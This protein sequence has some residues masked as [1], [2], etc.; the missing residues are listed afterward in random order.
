ML[1]HEFNWKREVLQSEEPVLV[2]F[3]AAWCGPCR[4]LNPV[5]ESLAK[6]YKVCKVNIDTNQPL[7]AHYNVTAVPTIMIFH[8]GKVVHR[9]VGLASES[10]LQAEM[11]ALKAAAG[12]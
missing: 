12:H 1:L 5:I 2:D 10:T 8:H 4:A 11:E 3:W 6:E 7:A 9:H